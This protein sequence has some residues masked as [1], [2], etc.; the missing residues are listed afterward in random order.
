[1]RIKLI[2]WINIRTN[3]SINFGMCGNERKTD[4]RRSNE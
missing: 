4:H 3:L 1:M 2:K